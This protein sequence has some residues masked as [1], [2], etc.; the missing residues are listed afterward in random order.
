MSKRPPAKSPKRVL[1]KGVRVKVQAAK[2]TL[3]APPADTGKLKWL[4]QTAEPAE[5]SES[6]ARALLE[7]VAQAILAC[8]KEGRIVMA[9]ASAEKMFGYPREALI[10]QNLESL[11]PERFRAAHR[12]RRAAWFAQPQNSPVEIDVNP[13]GLRKDGP[14]FP[15][16]VNLSVIQAGK[17]ALAVFFVSD[18][19]ERKRNQAQLKRLTHAL[20]LSQEEDNRE[21][22]RELHDVFSQELLAIG[23]QLSSL[24]KDGQSEA[25]REARLSELAQK[26]V[27][28]S[29]QLHEASR[30]LHPAILEDL[31]LEPAL[32]QECKSFQSA[33]GIPTHFTAKNVPAGIALN[34]A[35]CLYRVAQECLRNI[36]KHA[37]ATDQV[38]VSLTGSPGGITLVVKDRGNGFELDG[39]LRNGGLGLISMEERVRAEDG[40]LTIESKPGE[41]TMVTAFI[42]FENSRLESSPQPEG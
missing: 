29:K 16:E 15:I 23:M 3:A 9:N 28:L 32:R 31:G 34:Q 24:K 14:E 12:Q 30:N 37:P 35:L 27:D 25:D 40:T 8:N 4:Q 11:I 42:P 5:E 10:G 20:L 38:W 26:A 19:T 6:I 18:I 2:P 13:V 22:A 17:E 36:H 39:A 1:A 33:C 41:G 21:I 7:N